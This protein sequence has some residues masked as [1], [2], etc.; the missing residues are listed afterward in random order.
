MTAESSGLGKM[1]QRV[2]IV[3]Q[4]LKNNENLAATVRK[5]YTR[6]GWNSILTSSTEMIN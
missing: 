2:F 1:Q 4:Y 6:Y 5:F 3:E